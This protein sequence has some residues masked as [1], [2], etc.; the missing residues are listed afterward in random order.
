MLVGQSVTRGTLVAKLT[1]MIIGELHIKV[2]KQ[3]LNKIQQ[4]KIDEIAQE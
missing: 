4:I 3:S 1:V 2:H